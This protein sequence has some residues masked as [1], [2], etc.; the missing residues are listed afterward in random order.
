MKQ[1]I[2]DFLLEQRNQNHRTADGS[3]IYDGDNNRTISGPLC[4]HDK[5]TQLGDIKVVLP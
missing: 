5:L 2:F 1:N 4:Q 3:T